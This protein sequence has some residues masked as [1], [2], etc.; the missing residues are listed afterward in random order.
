MSGNLNKL[1]KLLVE[2]KNIKSEKFSENF[3][4]LEII[5][6]EMTNLLVINKSVQLSDFLEKVVNIFIKFSNAKSTKVISNIISEL[7]HP[8]AKW[9]L[10]CPINLCLKIIK[11]CKIKNK[12]ILSHRIK[13]QLCELYYRTKRYDLAL[14]VMNKLLKEIKTLDNKLLL[15][16]L[17]ML[18]SRIQH[19]LR[20][21]P[22]AKAALTACRASASSLYVN[23]DLHTNIDLQAGIIATEENEYKIAYSYFYEAFEGCRV[24]KDKRK[25]KKS[26]IY[27]M[28]C[29]IM[30]KN[31]KELNLLVNNKVILQFNGH[32]VERM[33][34]I[35]KTCE[36]RSLK[37]LEQILNEIEFEDT[38]LKIKI[39]QIR[40]NLEEENIIKIL[41]P[42][43]KVQIIHISNLIDLPLDHVTRKLS[44]MILDKKIDGILDQG[45]GTLIKN[46]SEPK[47]K[48]FLYALDLLEKL[49][50]VVEQFLVTSYIR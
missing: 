49:E 8:S 33:Y 36:K 48:T 35:S 17:H 7:S 2:F 40:N 47:L 45:T 27:M 1:S 39:N 21:I 12:K 26:L 41:E 46:F 32:S 29:K 22:K 38:L 37:E 6:K 10:Q 23:P 25:A 31:F 14:K 24:Q 15:V 43:S 44:Q 50:D 19:N 13:Q 30:S 5:V 28:L 9:D 20:N 16:E 4:T 11:N 3:T 34:A 42:Y 18:E